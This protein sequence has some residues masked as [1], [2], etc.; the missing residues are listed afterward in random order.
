[1][2]VR[3]QRITS[4]SAVSIKWVIIYKLRVEACIRLCTFYFSFIVSD[5]GD[6]FGSKL[7]YGL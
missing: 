4:N 5:W 3:W 2:S 7:D 6:T 1:M